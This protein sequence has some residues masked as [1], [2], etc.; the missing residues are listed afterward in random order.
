MGPAGNN[1]RSERFRWF[2]L[3]QQVWANDADRHRKSLCIDAGALPMGSAP[4]VNIFPYLILRPGQHILTCYSR[5]VIHKYVITPRR[6][7]IHVYIL[8]LLP[9]PCPIKSV[10]ANHLPCRRRIIRDA[11][12]SERNYCV[13]VVYIREFRSAG[14]S[15]IHDNHVAIGSPIL[16]GTRK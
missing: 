12:R 11:G 9:E 14:R 4:G 7:I 15:R 13:I 2:R 10:I 16:R 3:R 1:V 5:G 6:L 8:I